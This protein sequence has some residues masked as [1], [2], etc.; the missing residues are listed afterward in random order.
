MAFDSLGPIVTVWSSVPYVSCHASTVYVP[1][2]RFAI[3]N[4][5]VSEVTAKYGLSNTNPYARIQG[6]TLQR[7]GI[8]NSVR[9]KV[10]LSAADPT[11]GT[12]STA[13]CAS[14]SGGR[15]ASWDRCFLSR[16]ADASSARPRAAR[17][18]SFLMQNHGIFRRVVA[19]VAETAFHVDDHIGERAI[20]PS[21][22]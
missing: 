13:G 1:G 22:C 14:A 9:A 21:Y 4:F 6:C 10:D 5:P 7:I 2:G 11:G 15:C 20:L 18:C 3:S 19:V 16:R 17:T 12:C 8:A